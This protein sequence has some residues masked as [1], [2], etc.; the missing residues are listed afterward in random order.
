[1]HDLYDYEAQPFLLG[2]QNEDKIKK[3][4]LKKSDFDFKTVVGV[5]MFGHVT[6]AKHKVILH[7]CCA[8][9]WYIYV[10]IYTY[11]WNIRRLLLQV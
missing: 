11:Q 2:F 10:P 7:A 9:L 1:V 4:G 5:S 3:N 8:A 6:L